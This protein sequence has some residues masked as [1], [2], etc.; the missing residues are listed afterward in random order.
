LKCTVI[1]E[2]LVKPPGSAR[3]AEMTLEEEVRTFILKYVP[4]GADYISSTPV[5]PF[6]GGT[7]EDIFTRKICV[8]ERTQRQV[9]K[10]LRDLFG[11]REPWGR[12][13]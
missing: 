13:R 10:R 12:G 11:N 1:P 6:G 5:P 3:L 9:L 2:V 8:S 4:N 7:W